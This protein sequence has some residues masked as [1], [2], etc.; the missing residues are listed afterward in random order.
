MR[1][2]ENVGIAAMET[3]AAPVGGVAF[4]VVVF[5]GG[6]IEVGPHV[7]EA[8]EEGGWVAGVEVYGAVV[9]GWVEG[10]VDAE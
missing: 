8:G 2:L 4:R 1:E 3:F 6:G 7:V 10:F 9:E 5:V